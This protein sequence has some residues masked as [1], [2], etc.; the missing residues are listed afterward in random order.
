MG[1]MT[2]PALLLA[3]LLA[4]SACAEQRRLLYEGRSPYTQLYVS[5]DAK[6]LRYLQFE[7]N[8][9]LQSVVRPGAP[10]HLELA[11]LRGAMTA[12]AFVPAPR[13]V[14][15][16]GLGGGSMPMFLRSL[17][18]SLSI[19]VVDIDPEVV[20]VAHR[21]FGLKEDARLRVHVADG[22]RFIEESRGGYDLVFLDAYGPDSIPF[23]LATRE[24]LA[25][26]QRA[27]S[28]G[29]LVVGNVWAAPNPLFS[30][31]VRTYQAQFPSVQVLELAGSVN[32][33]VFARAAATAP[34]LEEVAKQGSALS[35]QHGLSFDLGRLLTRG[36]RDLR[37]SEAKLGRVL[38]DAEDPDRQ[39]PAREA[40]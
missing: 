28:P 33:I 21:F 39:Q 7:P 19:D 17:Y 5:E 40:R 20:K 32:R 24:F 26:V 4:T 15:V 29:G 10:R 13:R 34:S 16:V 23:H 1:R 37:P 35:R 22:R 30:S 9:A 6:G 38:L 12:L 27:L 25:A 8:G 2:R 14:L 18:P 3:L 36:L 31:M 11:Y